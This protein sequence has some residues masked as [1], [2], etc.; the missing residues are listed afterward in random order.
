MTGLK[1]CLWCLADEAYI[2]YHDHEWGRPVHDD[3]LLFEML[4]LEG[5]QAGLSWLQ[6]LRR[7]QAYREAFDDFDAEKIARYT[8]RR[9][10]RL[11]QNPGIIRNTLKIEAFVTNAQAYLETVESF[12]TFDEYIWQFTGHRVLDN[13]PR[14]M[15][16]VPAVT[17][18]SD[19]MSRDLKKR[20]FKFTGSTICYAY[21][22]S[23]GL[24]NDHLTHCFVRREMR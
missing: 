12:G 11:M 16:D 17:A 7:R 13:K 14:A 24:V 23:C 8:S 22:Q 5:A 20:G 6:I 3:S 21:M 10:E 18:E 19:A 15:A 9:K 4:L 2:A 1:R